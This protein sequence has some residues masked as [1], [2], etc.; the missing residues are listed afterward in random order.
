MHE[1]ALTE[2]ILRTA[3][4]HAQQAGA[5]RLLAVNLA[6][7]QLSE[8]TPDSIR[9]YWEFIS[10]G[11]L[12]EGATL[13]FEPLPCQWVCQACDHTFPPGLDAPVCPACGSDQVR[14]Q[15]NEGVR[16]I[17]LDVETAD[18]PESAIQA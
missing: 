6:V 11:T 10:Q 7:G 3:L 17:S 13:N 9:F 4:A 1:L 16:L 15:G 5:R 12:G 2:N 14:W 18:T 8:L